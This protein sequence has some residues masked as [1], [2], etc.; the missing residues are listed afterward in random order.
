MRNVCGKEE[1]RSVFLVQ[2]RGGGCREDVCESGRGHSAHRAAAVRGASTRSPCALPRERF[3]AAGQAA[4]RH[5]RGRSAQLDPGFGSVAR[6][7]ASTRRRYV[8]RCE[9]VATRR[10]LRPM[11]HGIILPERWQQSPTG[12]HEDARRHA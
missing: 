8:L 11:R 10:L 4:E 3:V 9:T 1:T 7:L 6:R 5:I 12:S 2:R